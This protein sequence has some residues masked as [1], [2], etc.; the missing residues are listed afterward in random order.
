MDI[1][2]YI[3]NVSDSFGS[4]TFVNSMSHEEQKAQ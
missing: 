1:K 2:H 4:V 3:E